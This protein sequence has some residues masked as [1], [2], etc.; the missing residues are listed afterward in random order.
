MWLMW[1]L[2]CS[3]CQECLCFSRWWNVQNRSKFLLCY[4][5][6]APWLSNPMHFPCFFFFL[7]FRVWNL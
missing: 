2:L 3:P 4:F 6:L 1:Y 7:T 5:S